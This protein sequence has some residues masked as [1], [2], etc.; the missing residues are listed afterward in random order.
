MVNVDQLSL[1]VTC[2]LHDCMLSSS[3]VDFK[4]VSDPINFTQ[5]LQK[6]LIAPQKV[7]HILHPQELTL[8][9]S[10]NEDVQSNC[11]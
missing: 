9:F 3:I 10:E 2:S 8:P 7:I 6:M 4:N 11:E 5:P 1:Y